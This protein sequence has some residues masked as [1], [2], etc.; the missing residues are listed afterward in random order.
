MPIEIGGQ[1]RSKTTMTGRLLS[2]LS[3]TA[4]MVTAAES[5]MAPKSTHMT[6]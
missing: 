3:K 1:I 2:R 5:A 4:A 6:S